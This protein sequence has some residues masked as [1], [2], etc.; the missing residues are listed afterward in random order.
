MFEPRRCP[1]SARALNT[2]IPFNFLLVGTY[3]YVPQPG[4]VMVVNRYAENV[5]SASGYWV[6]NIFN[7]PQTTLQLAGTFI[8]GSHNDYHPLDQA[9][10][11]VWA[12][13][14]ANYDLLEKW[15]EMPGNVGQYAT[16]GPVFGPS[17]V[18]LGQ[19]ATYAKVTELD[20][21]SYMYQWSVN[22]Q[23]VNGAVGNQYARTFLS[24]GTHVLSVVTRTSDCVP[25]T[26]S[27]TVTALYSASIAGPS[28]VHKPC[29]VQYEG[30][31]VGGVPS[32][33][34]AWTS[35][36]ASLGSSSTILDLTVNW[37]GSRTLSVTV[38]DAAGNAASA[39]KGVTGTTSGQ[40]VQ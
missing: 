15:I 37:L 7:S 25:D 22:G 4:G 2:D 40:C 31:V 14:Q 30:A 13:Y 6:E 34:F 17:S 33:S 19:T 1:Y 20:S 23:Q 36:G 35:N 24:P 29:T 38:T 32:L 10:L 18:V 27:I 3:E 11:S 26:A 9:R 39:S 28:T 12:G 16:G 21:I 5:G 8:G